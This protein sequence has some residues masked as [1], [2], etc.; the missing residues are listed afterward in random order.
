MQLKYLKQ[1][2]SNEMVAFYKVFNKKD[3]IKID[4]TT[5]NQYAKRF[6]SS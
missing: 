3:R 5:V 1:L 6:K 4:T 2:S